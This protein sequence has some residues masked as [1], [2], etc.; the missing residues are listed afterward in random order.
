V[1]FGIGSQL[2]FQFR[3]DPHVRGR[4]NLYSN[5]AHQITVETRQ[6]AALFANMAAVALGWTRQEET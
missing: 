2:A 5:E 3:A 6:L 4:V 1:Q